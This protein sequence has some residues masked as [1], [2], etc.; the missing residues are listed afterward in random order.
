L[1]R[2]VRGPVC[3]GLRRPYRSSG[4]GT[5]QTG[6]ARRG[7]VGRTGAGGP[8]QRPVQ[9][10]GARAL[11]LPQAAQTSRAPPEVGQP[12]SSPRT[13]VQS[14]RAVQRTEAETGHAASGTH[15]PINV[16]AVQAAQRAHAC[17][18]ERTPGQRI[19]LV[20]RHP[21]RP[22]RCASCRCE[23]STAASLLAASSARLRGSAHRRHPGASAPP[24]LLRCSLPFVEEGPWAL[25]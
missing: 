11:R 9:A 12:Q 15:R 18:R 23:Q 7:A 8:I 2:N 13:R 10:T 5:G 20:A 6:Q 21:V 17:A 4:A 1:R 16:A 14:D 22:P 19:T 3:H 25:L 24:F